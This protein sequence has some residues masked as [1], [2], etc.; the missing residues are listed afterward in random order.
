MYTRY[1]LGGIFFPI[2]VADCAAAAIYSRA[3]IWRAIID[4][5]AVKK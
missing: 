2:P 5:I 1:R 3:A 4:F